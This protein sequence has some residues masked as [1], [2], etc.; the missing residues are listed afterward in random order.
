MAQALGQ[1]LT[2]I[3]IK[4]SVDAMTQTVFFPHRAKRDFSLAMGG[5]G[6]DEPSSMLRTWIVSTDQSRALGQ[7][8]YGAYHNDALDAL[9]VPALEDMDSGRRQKRLQQATDIA[10]H[11][12]AII[13]LYWETTTWAFKDRYSYTGRLDQLTDVDGLV[14]KEK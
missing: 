9:V 13:P 7:S 14:S 3:G 6:F 5:W 4:V 11:D 1:Y 12:N 10:L 8:N 2:R